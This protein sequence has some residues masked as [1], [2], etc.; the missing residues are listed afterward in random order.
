MWRDLTIHVHVEKTGSSSLRELLNAAAHIDT[1]RHTAERPSE[2][3]WLCIP[4]EGVIGEDNVPVACAQ[5]EVAYWAENVWG[6]GDV[7]LSATSW[8]RGHRMLTTLRE[9]IERLV[10]E[11]GYFC[12][13]CKDAEKYC[14]RIVGTDCV[15]GQHNFSAWAARAP[16]PYT[17]QFAA[18]WPGLSFR[19]AKMRGFPDAPPVS[20][21]DVARAVITL[22]RDA[23]F[24]IWQDEMSGMRQSAVIARLRAWLGGHN[25]SRAAAA[26]THVDHFPH[27]N[28]LQTRFKYSPSASER[29]LA[30]RL[31]AA[32][33]DLYARL[34][35]DALCT[36]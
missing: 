22:A 8:R 12:L 13:R 24:V 5:S 3:S 28:A 9:P 21:G 23:T 10:S 15:N 31:Y 11:F 35:P 29:A 26:L 34:R 2:S 4:T 25:H 1:P 6:S 17:R 32:D 19:N 27:E 18:F 16:N 7:H 20:E 33:C 30:C 14:G 36:C